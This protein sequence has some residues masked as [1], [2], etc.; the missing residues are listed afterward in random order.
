MS[1]STPASRVLS[2]YDFIKAQSRT[3]PVQVLCRVLDVAQSGYYVWLKQPLS[4]ARKWTPD[5][6]D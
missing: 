1:K 6:C 5:S 3:F 4:T 2:T